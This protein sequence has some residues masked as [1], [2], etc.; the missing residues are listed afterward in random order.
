MFGSSDDLIAESH[1]QL[2]AVHV[3]D[4]RYLTMMVTIKIFLS[5]S[6]NLHLN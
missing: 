3:I 6:D 2:M 1:I 4:F 5:P